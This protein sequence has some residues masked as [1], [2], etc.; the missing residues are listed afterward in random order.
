[1]V[2]YAIDLQTWNPSAIRLSAQLG[3]WKT[4][5][6]LGA[7]GRCTPTTE[8]PCRPC[9]SNIT[10][11]R[12]ID[13]DFYLHL[14]H[15]LASSYFHGCTHPWAIRVSLRPRTKKFTYDE[16]D[17][18]QC[19]CP[20]KFLSWVVKALRAI[21]AVKPATTSQ[22]STFPM[23]SPEDT[24]GAARMEEEPVRRRAHRRRDRTR[25]RS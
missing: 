2:R 22:S 20:I 25:A 19:G 10:K 13:R 12:K 1:M 21:L 16:E 3:D 15:V 9:A 17:H 11:P 14:A 18:E 5:N 4:K 8:I 7:R 24:I 23:R 6:Q